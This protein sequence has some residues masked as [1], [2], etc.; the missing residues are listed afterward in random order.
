M[1]G[2]FGQ[3]LASPSRTSS[4]LSSAQAHWNRT[5]HNDP[6]DTAN[7]PHSLCAYEPPLGL[8]KPHW[9]IRSTRT[10]CP[11]GSERRGV[12]LYPGQVVRTSSIASSQSAGQL[13]LE[14]AQLLRDSK[15]DVPRPS[16][17]SG[18]ARGHG[19]FRAN[20]ARRS[21]S[22]MPSDT[23]VGVEGPQQGNSGLQTS[24][25]PPLTC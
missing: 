14:I 12:A 8:K 11:K 9:R 15:Y 4:P 22:G 17:C 13:G 24:R 18:A 16:S 25:H 1:V 21:Q 20:A 10:S 23:L 6:L 7:A 3:T 5:E 19:R 2:P